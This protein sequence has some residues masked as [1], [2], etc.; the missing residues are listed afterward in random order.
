[1]TMAAYTTDAGARL[2]YE[3]DDHTDPWT[4][5]DV[6]LLLHGIA[7]TGIALRAWAPHLS[8]KY[9]VVRPDLRGFGQSSG[10]GPD[11]LRGVGIWADDME[12]L[13]HVLGATRVHVVGAKLGALV[14]ME[15]A[16]R[17]PAWMKT[18]VLAGL[19]MS[20]KRV[21]GPWIPGWISLIEREGVEAWARATMPGRMGAALGAEA[22]QWWN[23]EMGAASAESLKT[24]LAMVADVDEPEGLEDVTIPTL[25]MVAAGGDKDGSFEQRQSVDVVDRFR[26]RFPVSELAP[27]EA[28]SY[29]VAATHPDACATIARRFIDARS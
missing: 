13:V 23:R 21:I 2:H 5:P 14:A 20:P 17:R 27:V 11:P 12:A 1:M 28:D 18:L 22:L 7:E 19:L 3:V 29:H 6:V 15:L 25:V 8:R 24:C 9:R 10:L 26:S 16:M 4:S